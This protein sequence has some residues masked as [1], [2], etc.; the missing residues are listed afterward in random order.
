MLVYRRVH[1]FPNGLNPL[2]RDSPWQDHPE[3]ED[4]LLYCS[5]EDGTE[6]PRTNHE[7]PV[8]LA[9]LMDFNWVVV[10]IFFIFTPI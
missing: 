4:T 3:N 2:C 5:P 7:S 1:I 8:G 6:F 10:S 9:N